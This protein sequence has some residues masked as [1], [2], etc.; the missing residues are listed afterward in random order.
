MRL[1]QKLSKPKS[2]L[3]YL[4]LLGAVL[5]LVFLLYR[6]FGGKHSHEVTP[7]DTQAVHTQESSLKNPEAADSDTL[8]PTFHGKDDRNASARNLT[9]EEEQALPKEDLMTLP[10][11][12]PGSTPPGVA[13]GTPSVGKGPDS[14]DGK[15][16][17]QHLHTDSHEAG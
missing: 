13:P 16:E 14:P 7:S 9:P 17:M 5:I 1:N 6:K 11:V 15:L 2:A 8:L 10:A 12:A 3:S 4:Y